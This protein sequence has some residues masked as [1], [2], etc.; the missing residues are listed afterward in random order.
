MK[1]AAE[2]LGVQG[3][4]QAA[5]ALVDPFAVGAAMRGRYAPLFLVD[6]SI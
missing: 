6:P 3:L 2:L 1:L 4:L 5:V